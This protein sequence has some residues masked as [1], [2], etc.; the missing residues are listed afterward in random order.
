MRKSNQQFKAIVCIYPWTRVNSKGEIP[1]EGTIYMDLLNGEMSNMAKIQSPLIAIQQH[2]EIGEK[3]L[4]AT[5]FKK[6]DA[7]YKRNIYSVT[8]MRK[9]TEDTIEAGSEKYGDPILFDKD[10]LEHFE[11]GSSYIE[12]DDND[13][14]NPLDEPTKTPKKE[15]KK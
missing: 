7:E 9:Y 8:R 5:A 15:I 11:N 4:I 13:K 2:L 14:G 10:R 12:K 1:P 6:Y 3:Y